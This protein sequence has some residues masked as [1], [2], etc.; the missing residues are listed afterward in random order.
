M[1]KELVDGQRVGVESCLG[2]EFSPRRQ[3]RLWGPHNLLSNEWVLGIKRPGREGDHSPAAS[4][5]ENVDLYIHS[6]PH[7]PS[8]CST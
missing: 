3:D 7:M 5:R 2:Q 4:A 6:P 1:Q 8:W